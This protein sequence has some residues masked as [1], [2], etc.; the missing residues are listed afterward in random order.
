MNRPVRSDPGERPVQRELPAPQPVFPHLVQQIP[1]T[2][3][4]TLVHHRQSVPD[5]LVHCALPGVS[6][7]IGEGIVSAG[8][9]PLPSF[10]NEDRQ[11]QICADLDA[12]SFISPASTAPA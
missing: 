2:A 4:P 3:R 1:Q 6:P 10:G 12:T 9:Q 5:L 7:A 11:A 8:E